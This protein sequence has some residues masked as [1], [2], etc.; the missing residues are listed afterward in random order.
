MLAG[1]GHFTAAL[2]LPL[3]YLADATVTLLR[4]LAEGEPITQAHRSHFYQRAIDGGLTAFQVVSRVFLINVGLIAL[5][6]GDPAGAVA[7]DNAAVI[8]GGLRVRRLGASQ[9][10]ARKPVS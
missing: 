7:S 3:Y 2:L 5:A 6:C 1:N 10:R 8:G 4:R 9:L